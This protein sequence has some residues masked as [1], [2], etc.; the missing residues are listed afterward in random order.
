MNLITDL[1]KRENDYR[2]RNLDDVKL[3]FH[4][5]L[6]NEIVNVVESE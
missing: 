3:E 1:A 4:G 6:N 5:D 2:F